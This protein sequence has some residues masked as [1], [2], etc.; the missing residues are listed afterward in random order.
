MT[1]GGA[2]FAKEESADG[3]S[4][5]FMRYP[6]RERSPL[7]TQPLDG[8]PERT[9]AECLMGWNSL[10]FRVHARGIYYRSCGEGMPIRLLDPATGRSRLFGSL[11]DDNGS[12]FAVSPDGKTILYA[13]G[14]SRSPDIMMIENF[15]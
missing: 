4:L 13:R 6:E 7:V 10:T 11:P 5:L 2:S 9:L 14:T 3:R 1:H 15:Q 8:G 12:R